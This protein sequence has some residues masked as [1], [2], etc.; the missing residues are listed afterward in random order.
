[1][2]TPFRGL[3]SNRA[4]A[5]TR[6]SPS[7][8]PHADL[9]KKLAEALEQQTATSEVLRV[10]S[11]SP[12]ELEPVLQ[13]ML[14]SAMRICEAKFGILLEYV[15]G[16]FRALS[17]RKIPPEFAEFLRHPRVWGPETGL[18]RLVRSK[19][20]VHVHDARSGRPYDHRDVDR[21]AAVQLGGVRT[22][23]TVPL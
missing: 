9:E 10:I 1:S 8:E 3:R 21:M 14:A 16:A 19:K 7:R 20:A 23:V 5:R 4:K 22:F 18:G 15:D 6:V 13:A 12:G 11:N 17:W 2:R